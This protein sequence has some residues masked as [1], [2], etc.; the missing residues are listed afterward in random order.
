MKTIN[1][2]IKAIKSQLKKALD[3][4]SDLPELTPTA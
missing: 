4:I 2:T 3:K 1:E